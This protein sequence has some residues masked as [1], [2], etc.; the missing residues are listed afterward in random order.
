[1]SGLAEE[2]RRVGAAAP[3]L[4]R[5]VPVSRVSFSLTDRSAFNDA[6]SLAV[7]WAGK[8]S[9][10]SLP[11]GADLG[12]SFEF[13]DDK[14]SVSALR[15]DNDEGSVWAAKLV[16]RG[17][18]TAQREWITDLFVEQRQG[19]FARFG[20][21]LACECLHSDPGFDHSRPRVVKDILEKLAG[22][23]DGE[24]L[25][26]SVEAV[27]FTDVSS[28]V[29]LLYNP[30]RR[31][32]VVLVSVD[33]FGGA[34][35]ELDRLA[36]RLS[37][38]A[39]LRSVAIEESFELS[40][41]IGQRMSTFNG[42]VRTYMPGLEQE[43]E[44]PFQHPLWLV[45]SSGRN[46]RLLN[47]I[48]SRV[49]PLG[50][51]DADGDA[52]FWRVSLIRQAT[53]RD[54][55]NTSTGTREEQLSA[56]IEALHSERDE[57]RESAAAAEALMYEEAAKLTV[58]QAEV[59]KLEEDNYSLRERIKSI[60]AGSSRSAIELDSA[61]V[62]AVFDNDSSLESSLRIVS[63]VFPDR[64][65]V[66]ESAFDSAHESYAFRHRKKAFSLLW[67]LC[68]DYWAALAEG[69][70]DGTAKQCFGNGFAAKEAE[71]IS[72]AGLKRR[73]FVYNGT[74]ILMEKHLKI[75]VA[76][77]KAETL[78]VHFEWIATEQ[79][80]AI[81]YCGGHLDF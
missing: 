21:Q 56:E 26:N 19:A 2:L 73:T 74:E 70:G 67:S 44:D 35:I 58:L 79:R 72:G 47:Q 34:Q 49:L 1:M 10:A 45:P 32:P 3:D 65:V 55:A 53:L 46:P 37:G 78:R 23:A 11:P 75:G 61:D 40:R 9:G 81:G 41:L 25:G 71:S 43:T 28:L 15:I 57:L 7:A 76:D 33:D 31:L 14:A 12:E 29:S 27:S 64:V 17:D 13:T 18:R 50:F 24:A 42:A 4:A 80:I 16:F 48:A 36:T 22:E 66:L 52:R 69:Q 30:A 77:N 62:R 54:A 5:R 39:H 60:A 59:A 38:A 63:A 51:R 6:V 20:A 68:T 8:T